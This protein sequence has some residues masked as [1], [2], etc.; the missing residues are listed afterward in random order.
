VIQILTIDPQRPSLR[1][2][3]EGAALALRGHRRSAPAEAAGG[4]HRRPESG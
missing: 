3:I 2:D 1:A 4:T